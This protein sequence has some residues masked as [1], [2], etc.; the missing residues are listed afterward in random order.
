MAWFWLKAARI[1]NNNKIHMKKSIKTTLL[2]LFAGAVT[3]TSCKKDDTGSVGGSGT[4]VNDACRIT[5]FSASIFGMDQTSNFIYN[6]SKQLVEITSAD[7][8]KEKFTYNSSGLVSTVENYTND[9]LT[10]YTSYTYN[11]T[12][13]ATETEYNVTD[14]VKGAI[15]LISRYTY[16][17]GKLTKKDTYSVDPS[18]NEETKI[19]YTN[20]NSDSKG[21]ITLTETYSRDSDSTFAFSTSEKYT[22]GTDVSNKGLNWTFGSGVE[23]WNNIYLPLTNV[24]ESYAGAGQ[25]NDVNTTSFTFSNK[26][27]KGFPA[28]INAVMGTLNVTAT[29]TYTCP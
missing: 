12:Q 10:D 23:F 26:N 1:K 11:G 21:N 14:G 25:P 13:F 5:Q 7:G 4:T 3:F 18:T 15:Q 27:A 2:V 16:S 28:T 17:A 20:Y 24:T 9:T 8:G 6:A 22:Y 19:N 29:A